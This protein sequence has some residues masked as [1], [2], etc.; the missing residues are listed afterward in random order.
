MKRSYA[1]PI[2]ENE[3]CILA[4]EIKKDGARK[5]WQ[6]TNEW[7]DIT[8]SE[9]LAIINFQQAFECSIQEV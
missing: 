1:I 4:K 6:C 7:K 5:Q 9:E 2:D 8:Q 3:R